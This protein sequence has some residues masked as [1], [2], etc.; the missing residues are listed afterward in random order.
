M[1]LETIGG[2][3]HAI[4]LDISPRP[5]IDTSVGY[6]DEMHRISM[7]SLLADPTIGKLAR[8]DYR[9]RQ[10][11]NGITYLFAVAAVALPFLGLVAIVLAVRALR[12]D[13]RGP[14]TWVALVVSVI[15]TA[16]GVIVWV[17]A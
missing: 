8:G 1:K 5:C 12:K 16:V 17:T 9:A 4:T 10:M 2:L 14:S 7:S 13:D 11:S 6:D 15:A 3:R